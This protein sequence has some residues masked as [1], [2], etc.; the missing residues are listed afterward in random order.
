MPNHSRRF[1]DGSMF[2]LASAL[3]PFPQ[4]PSTPVS[5]LFKLLFCHH[6]THFSLNLVRSSATECPSPLLYISLS[7]VPY[8]FAERLRSAVLLSPLLTSASKHGQRR[9]RRYSSQRVH[10]LL[11]L[12][13]LPSEPSA[14]ALTNRKECHPSSCRN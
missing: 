6:I 4:H 9:L 14:T 12:F 10:R 7:H 2:P 1:G 3:H 11:S 5:Q 8:E 13:H